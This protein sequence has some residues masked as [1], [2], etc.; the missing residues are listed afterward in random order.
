MDHLASPPCT[1]LH[2]DYRFDNLLYDDEA[3]FVTDFQTVLRGRPAIDLAYFVTGSVVE[4][5]DEDVLIDAYCDELVTRGITGYDGDTCRRDYV[6][7]KMLF[8]Y[9]HVA[10]EDLIDL[11]DERGAEL[12]AVM[13]KRLFARVPDP[14]YDDLLPER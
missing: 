6:L 9:G 13:R 14:P 7:S 11:G 12:L 4:D 3:M 1:L 2:G 10:A 5:V 8:L